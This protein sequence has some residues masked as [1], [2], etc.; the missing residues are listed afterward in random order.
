MKRRLSC[1]DF[2][3]CKRNGQTKK[4]MLL[5]ALFVAQHHYN[6]V[7]KESYSDDLSG[8]TTNNFG[9]ETDSDSQSSSDEELFPNHN[10]HVQV[11]HNNVPRKTL[12][13][14]QMSSEQQQQQKQKQKQSLSLNK[15]SQQSQF[16]LSS[17]Q[18]KGT[19]E[20]R[21][22]RPHVLERNVALI[23][24]ELRNLIVFSKYSRH[25]QARLLSCELCFLRQS[26]RESIIRFNFEYPLCSGQIFTDP[27]S[28]SIE[29]LWDWRKSQTT[30]IMTRK[31]E[32]FNDLLKQA[33]GLNDLHYFVRDGSLPLSALISDTVL[34]GERFFDIPKMK[35][36][37]K[38][39]SASSDMSA[40]NVEKVFLS[41]PL[42]NNCE[43][44]LPTQ[45]QEHNYPRTQIYTLASKTSLSPFQERP[46][47]TQPGTS[48]LLTWTGDTIAE[49]QT[50]KTSSYHTYHRSTWFRG[51]HCDSLCAIPLKKENMT[52][53]RKIIYDS[54]T[55]LITAEFKPPFQLLTEQMEHVMKSLQTLSES[56]ESLRSALNFIVTTSDN[57][58]ST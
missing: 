39:F 48:Y 42:P 34:S 3:V 2:V 29:M 46:P 23:T 27:T 58:P 56:L 9:E 17:S 38:F 12:T 11:F 54:Q 40:K 4:E 33:N 45:T 44:C 1:S 15:T 25:L 14:A 35:K 6:K 36:P 8:N 32:T 50:N 7:A 30:T 41:A 53:K 21:F 57:K 28:L 22:L 49:K 16:R 26:S 51:Q 10:E 5:R 13:Q 18:P 19:Q 55:S 37:V 20:K 31:N 43:S 47:L 52:K 24:H